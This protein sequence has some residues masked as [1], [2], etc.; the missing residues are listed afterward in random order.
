[1]RYLALAFA[2]IATVLRAAESARPM[3]AI[4]VAALTPPEHT[5]ATSPAIVRGADGTI[6]LT[7]L[8]R[9]NDGNTALRFAAFDPQQKSWREPRTIARGANWFVNFA[10]FPTIAIGPGHTAVAVW[11]VNNSAPAASA[12]TH[13]HHGPGYTAFISQTAD[14]GK[15]WSRAA[16]LTR[17]S[18]S[19]EFVSLATL[20]D[21]R[22]LAV[23]LDG[24]AKK[25][26]GKAQQLYSRV[27]GSGQPDTL[28]DASVCDCCQTTLTAFPDGSALV[29]YRG[30][31]A[32]EIR[33]IRIARFRH[34]KWSEPR[35]LHADG[36][37][38]NGCPVN[39]PR[40]VSDG[41]RVGVAWF[42]AAEAKPRVL[43]SFSPDAG[44]RFVE[45]LRID[46][47]KPSGR[48]DTLLLRDGALLVTWLET[49]GTLALRRISPDFSTRESIALVTAT[50]ERI[51]GFPRLALLEDYRGGSSR[52]QLLVAYAVEGENAGLRTLLVTVPEGAL[53]EAEKNCDCAPTPEQLQG[54]PLRGKIVSI[55]QSRGTIR[56]Q[57]PD[58]PG[59]FERGAREFHVDPPLLAVATP[60][61]EFFGRVESRDDAWWLFDV[62]FLAVPAAP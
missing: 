8:E 55:D 36:W 45:P 23:W 14:G 4:D 29:A 27:L 57:H 44:A 2:L 48:V 32:T 31:S 53:L 24:R 41:G 49:D 40:L 22:V 51:K 61:R 46:A 5:R 30:R 37:Q 25:A 38:I 59:I 56:V 28:V 16:P 17:E 50:D 43:A 62:R 42:T 35:A 12:A 11:F 26:G 10:D 47:G 15:T 20:A 52:A 1:M 58:V 18:D 34:G 54:Y 13:D 33:D 21:G 19:V 39:G 7:W 3:P 60:G 6:W 9:E